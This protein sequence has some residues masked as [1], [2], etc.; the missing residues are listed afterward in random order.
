MDERTTKILK[1]FK[2]SW[3]DTKDFYDELIANYSGWD[4]LR[5]LLSFI[6]TLEDKGE[7]NYFR[8]GTSVDRLLISRSIDHGLRIDQKFIK[9]EAINENDFEV[10]LRD[11]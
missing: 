11:G 9:I 6:E 1:R 8:L 2:N 4:K 10:T 5:P 3:T 7:D